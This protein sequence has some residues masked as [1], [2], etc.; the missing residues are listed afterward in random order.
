MI[1]VTRVI[2]ETGLVPISP[3]A[4]AA[5]IVNR[6]AM[7]RTVRTLHIPI[8]KVVSA[9]PKNK[10]KAA[11]ARRIKIITTERFIFSAVRLSSF[12]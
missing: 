7:I 1:R 10:S 8:E 12:R 11:P 2:P 5:T 6:K 9:L 3:I 4:R